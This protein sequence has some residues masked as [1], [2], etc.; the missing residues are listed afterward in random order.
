MDDINSAPDDL[1]ARWPKI[2]APEG[3][4]VELAIEDGWTGSG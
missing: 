2:L 1:Y 4:K 3:R